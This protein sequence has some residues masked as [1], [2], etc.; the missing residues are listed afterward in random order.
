MKNRTYKYFK[1]EPLY[2]F[3]HGLSYTRFVPEHLRF[4]G[5]TVSLTLRNTGGMDAFET[6]EVFL[7]DKADDRV[8]AR[9]AGFKKVWLPAGGSVDVDV[10]LCPEI[11]ALFEHPGRL[12][13]VVG[14][15][16]GPELDREA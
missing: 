13:A 9:L 5:D 1:G 11:I 14:G 15:L 10:P 12:T 16:K 4:T 2:P 6:V 7:K 8:N 3:G